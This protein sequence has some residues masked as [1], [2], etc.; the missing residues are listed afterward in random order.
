MDT[1]ER[2]LTGEVEFRSQL[3]SH[4]WELIDQGAVVAKLEASDRTSRARLADGTVWEVIDDG[5]GMIRTVE[6]GV[7]F[8]R[9]TYNRP[10]PEEWQITGPGIYYTLQPG[11]IVARRW[12]LIGE[13][14]RAGTVRASVTTRNLVTISTVHPIPVVVGVLAWAVSRSNTARAPGGVKPELKPRDKPATDTAVG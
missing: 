3:F 6:A 12:E 5:M 2:V 10:Q 14:G 13:S 9:A 8:A 1:H 11:G 4:E 7:P